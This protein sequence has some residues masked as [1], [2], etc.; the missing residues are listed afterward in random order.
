MCEYVVMLYDILLGIGL[1]REEWVLPKTFLI[2]WGGAGS[3]KRGFGKSIWQA[4]FSDLPKLQGCV[5][6]NLHEIFSF[7]GLIVMT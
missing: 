6:I 1:S 3:T 4:L 5:R 2:H 7:I